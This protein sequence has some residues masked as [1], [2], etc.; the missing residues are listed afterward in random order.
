M[1]TLRACWHRSLLGRF[2]DPLSRADRVV[3]VGTPIAAVAFGLVFSG[4]AHP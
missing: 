4:L 2:L 3:I 1:K